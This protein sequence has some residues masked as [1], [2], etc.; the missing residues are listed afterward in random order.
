V[1]FTTIHKEQQ[2]MPTGS[3]EAGAATPTDG[4]YIEVIVDG[5]LQVYS[6]FRPVAW[7][8]ILVMVCAHK[9]TNVG[10]DILK[11]VHKLEGINVAKLELDMGI[12]DI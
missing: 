11:G 10:K 3:P 1:I 9:G 7:A 5:V 6:S 12:N 8:C 4:T 2:D